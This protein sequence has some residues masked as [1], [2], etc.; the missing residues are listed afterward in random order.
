MKTYKVSEVSKI[1]GI[2][3]HTLRY[4]DRIG[5]LNFV[6]RDENGN[7]AFKRS[8]FLALRTITCMKSTGM[9]LKDIKHYIDLCEEGLASAPERLKIMEDQQAEIED[10]KGEL[11]TTK[12]KVDYYKEAIKENNLD[13]YQDEFNEWLDQILGKEN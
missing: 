9:H 8:D 7:R 3:S 4:W 6:G 10:L 11:I 2:S 1:M 13:V 5:L 12:Q